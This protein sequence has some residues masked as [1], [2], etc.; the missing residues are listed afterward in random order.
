ML[1]SDIVVGVCCFLL[2]S[3]VSGFGGFDFDVQIVVGS[4]FFLFYQSRL[5]HL[6]IQA[7]T[8]GSHVM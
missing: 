8:F 4:S 3:D 2:A 1:A 5:V 7:N 6:F